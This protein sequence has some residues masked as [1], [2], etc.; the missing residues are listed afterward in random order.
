MTTWLS[1]VTF[2]QVSRSFGTPVA[3]TDSVTSSCVMTK[4]LTRRSDLAADWGR[5]RIRELLAPW[6]CRSTP[7]P[8]IC[9]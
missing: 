6:C 3:V 2:D 1:L 4:A 5:A 8:P 7:T 9:M